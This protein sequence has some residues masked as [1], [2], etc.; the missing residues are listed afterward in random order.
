M[1]N[2]CRKYP[3]QFDLNRSS[4]TCAFSDAQNSNFNFYSGWPSDVISVDCF[5]LS[6]LVRVIA[7]GAVPVP[8]RPRC[9]YHL[10]LY[11]DSRSTQMHL[12]FVPG[13][14]LLPLSMALLELEVMAIVLWNV[15]V[16]IAAADRRPIAVAI[17]KKR[18]R[19]HSLILIKLN[20]IH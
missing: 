9:C 3:N 4:L 14:S 17:P 11:F 7:S 20:A 19:T 8:T 15:S 6:K 2:K 18:I 12:V 10:A 13:I 16:A 5:M 1:W